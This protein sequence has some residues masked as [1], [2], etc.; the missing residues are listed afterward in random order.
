[1]HH[2]ESLRQNVINPLMTFRDSQ[3]RIRKRVKADV[4]AS[5]TD[6]EEGLKALKVCEDLALV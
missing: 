1:M 2:I 3:E 5:S 4:K 6:F